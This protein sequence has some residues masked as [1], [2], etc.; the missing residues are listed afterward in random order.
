MVVALVATATKSFAALDGHTY[1]IAQPTADTYVYRNYERRFLRRQEAVSNLVE[2]QN[3]EEKQSERTGQEKKE[4]SRKHS[5]DGS[6]SW[7]GSRRGGRRCK[8]RRGGG[9]RSRSDNGSG[10][11][12]TSYAGAPEV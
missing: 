5:W 2:V 11:A 9:R 12:Q 6:K 3:Q 10:I 8:H 1:A 4:K 7:Y